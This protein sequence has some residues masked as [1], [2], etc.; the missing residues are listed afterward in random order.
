[1]NRLVSRFSAVLLSFVM[2]LGLMPV[3]AFTAELDGPQTYS[4][5]F[6]NVV[7]DRGI[8]AEITT[9][10][11]DFGA[12]LEQASGNALVGIV[13][14]AESPEYQGAKALFEQDYTLTGTFELILWTLTLDGQTVTELPEGTTITYSSYEIVSGTADAKVYACNS[15]AL[16][17]VNGAVITDFMNMGLI[18]QASFTVSSLDSTIII[19]NDS[20]TEKEDTSVTRIYSDGNDY[21]SVQVTASGEAL[22][23]DGSVQATVVDSTYGEIADI[24]E[25]LE[26]KYDGDLSFSVYDLAL[27][28]AGD[29]ITLPDDAQT[30]ITVRLATTEGDPYIY[31]YTDGSLER[32]ITE[33]TDAGSSDTANYSFS[34]DSLSGIVI[35]NSSGLTVNRFSSF[36]PGRYRITANLYVKG[37]N[38][39]VLSGVTAY[40]TNP[41]LPPVNAMKNNAIM[42][43]DEDGN[44]TFTIDVKNPYFSLQQIEGGEDVHIVDSTYGAD[45]GAPAGFWGSYTGRIMQLIV[46]VD[47]LNGEYAFTNCKEYA[48][49]LEEEVEMPIHLGVDFDSAA[50]MLDGDGESHTFTD[51]AT[52]VAVTVQTTDSQLAETLNTAQ[53]SVTELTQ[54][55][56]YD[57]ARAAITEEYVDEPDFKLY[58]IHLLTAGNQEIAFTWSEATAVSL[59]LGGSVTKGEVCAIAGGSANKITVTIENSSASF[60]GVA[61]LGQFAV[62]DTDS[63]PA[64]I[65]TTCADAVTGIILKAYSIDSDTQPLTGLFAERNK[66]L[67]GLLAGKDT[68]GAYLTAALQALRASSG[69]DLQNPVVD[70][71]Y[72]I[73]IGNTV[74]MGVD[75]VDN[76]VP[77]GASWQFWRG[78]NDA[79]L[80]A[81]VPVSDADHSFYL[82]KDDGASV[83]ATPLDATVKN[84]MATIDL[85]PRSMSQKDGEARIFALYWGQRKVAPTTA[86]PISYVAA[87]KDCVAEKPA[88]ITGLKYTGSEQTGVAEGEGYTLTGHKAAAAG[89]YTATATLNAGYMWSDGTTAPV[90]IQWSIAANGSGAASET[91]TVTANLYVPGNLNAQLPGVNAYMTNGNNPQGIGGYEKKAPT[92][93]VSDNAKLTTD[94]DGTMT[95]VL[96]LPN[97]VFTLQ[98]IGGCDNAEI[99][100]I[101]RDNKTYGSYTGRITQITVELLD[102]SGTYVFEDC[103]EFPTLLG[104]DW[105]VPLTLDVKFSGGSSGLPSK[106]VDVDLDDLIGGGDKKDETVIKVDPKTDPVTETTTYEDGTVSVTVTQTDGSSVNTI[107]TP[108]NSTSETSTDTSGRVVSTIKL[109]EKEVA[110]LKAGAAMPLPMPG[111][112]VTNQLETAPSIKLASFGSDSATTLLVS[113]PASRV[114]PGTVAVMVKEDGTTQVVAGTRYNGGKLTFTAEKNVTYK[115]VDNSRSFQDT[116]ADSWYS[117]AVHY[118]SARILMNGTGIDTFS[119]DES[120]SRGMI[121][122]ILYRME[123]MPAV[124]GENGAFTDVASGQ[125]YAGAAAWASGQGIANGYSNGTF[126]P[127]DPI[128]REQLAVMLWRYAGSPSGTAALESFTDQD[129]VGSYAAEA[130]AWAVEKGVMSGKGNGILDPRGQA[131]R[132]QV[133]QMLMNFVEKAAN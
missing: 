127:N 25:L 98:E 101:R 119:P 34:T 62:V 76:L 77:T 133:A 39:Q 56:S 83:T 41:N 72:Q 1:M 57:T 63:I 48:T 10:D 118:V 22:P 23:E 110:N 31:Q 54:G 51:G 94:P 46:I 66:S 27:M 100:N 29:E 20:L 55:D 99:I 3:S 75:E 106:D 52:G 11:A 32:L 97:P 103:T 60:D 61:S 102:K 85:V 28:S 7:A 86:R 58:D 78:K 30:V 112:T 17:I 49:P 87:V 93:P 116:G 9:T 14:T 115:I 68:E 95:L 5:S 6:S 65:N 105:H 111:V 35:L 21:F 113:V 59:P 24:Q 33:K 40:L 2:L 130:M 109:S 80:K 114:T 107:K 120:T 50:R 18:F 79:F 91:K 8:A 71:S 117:D 64:W 36:T 69:T 124:S 122:T 88:A 81:M 15:E 92:E 38:N 121:V 89:N 19:E 67:V 96:N 131:T 47:S 123:G 70:A 53:L 43:V 16:S 129:Q 12:K 84:G 108:N 132:A 44:L 104:M 26:A 45:E 73:A 13:A 74:L 90:Q 37:E 82:I 128:T 4:K 126:G 125:Y 42:D